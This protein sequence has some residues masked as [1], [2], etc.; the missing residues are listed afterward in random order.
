M[1][2]RDERGDSL[3]DDLVSHITA[4]LSKSHAIIDPIFSPARK[5]SVELCLEKLVYFP[6]II[7][8]YVPLRQIFRAWKIISPL[9]S[10]L[11]GR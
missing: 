11:R 1:T 9:S 3:G 6:G 7:W 4:S 5:H 8:G 2:L 10:V